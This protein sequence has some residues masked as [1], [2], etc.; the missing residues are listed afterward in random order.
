MA[1]VQSQVAQMGA[2]QSIEFQGVGPAGPDIYSV[3]TD[4]G[5][6]ACRIRLTPEGKVDS[7]VI[8]PVQR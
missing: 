3:K 2:V 8:Q 1:T 4:K 5:S 7:V 6:W